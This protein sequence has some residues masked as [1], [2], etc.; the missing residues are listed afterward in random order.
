VATRR[1]AACSSAKLR[2]STRACALAIAVSASSVKAASRPSAPAGSGPRG[3]ATI[4]T[5]H[6]RP[7]TLTGTPTDAW[8]PVSW[9]V[10]PTSPEKSA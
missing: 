5:P 6:R 8:E 3:D 4:M 7:S 2:S 10:F 9:A 1:S